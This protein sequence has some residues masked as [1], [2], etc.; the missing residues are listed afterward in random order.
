MTLKGEPSFIPSSTEM[1]A[2][3]DYHL[4]PQLSSTL[5]DSGY[6]V[7]PTMNDACGWDQPRVSA[8][9]KRISKDPPCGPLTSNRFKR[10]NI[11]PV[12]Q[13]T[14]DLPTEWESLLGETNTDRLEPGKNGAT[15]Q[16]RDI[17]PS[18]SDV[19]SDAESK[20]CVTEACKNST[21]NFLHVGLL[22]VNSINDKKFDYI[23]KFLERAPFAIAVLTELS[24]ENTDTTHILEK[25]EKYPIISCP[26][27]RRVGLAISS[28]WRHCVEI[29][30]TWRFEEKRK[31]SSQIAVQVTT[32]RITF[33]TTVITVSGIYIVP[34]ATV[35][36]K[37][38]MC[39]K[40]G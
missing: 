13:C 23:V 10:L 3:S 22:N 20:K 34:E 6:R 32:Y 37:T 27:N 8:P 36:A 7:E 18:P 1:Q 17:D 11:E 5:R 14:N 31:R 25:H 4:L 26:L 28:A 38:A 16:V 24:S 33:S 15:A 30:D 40:I 21:K 39:Q 9:R 19:T 29:V 12:S 35:A 2:F